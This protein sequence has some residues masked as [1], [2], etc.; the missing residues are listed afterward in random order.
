[1]LSLLR[2]AIQARREHARNEK[3]TRAQLEALQLTKFRKLVRHVNARSPYYT[4]LISELG[5]SVDTC[6]PRDFPVL[7]K[8]ILMQ[9][10]DRIITERSITRQRIAEFLTR[11]KD[12]NELIDGRYHVLHTSGTSGEIGYFVYSEDDWARGLAQGMGRRRGRPRARRKR[13]GR[14]RGAFYG[15]IG[16]HFAGVSMASSASVGLG[17]LFFDL[18]LFE[19]NDPLPVVIHELNEFQPEFISGYTTA[20]KILAAKQREG[21]LKISPIAVGTGGETMTLADKAVLEEA[22]GCE[23]GSGYGCT[24]HLMMGSSTPG[25]RTMILYDDDLIFEFMEDHSLITN[26]Y[27]YTLPL[28]RYRMSDILRPIA[29]SSVSPYIEI[30]CLVGRNER[31]PVFINRDGAED[32]ISPHTINEIFVAGV[33]QFQMQLVDPSRFKFLVCLDP[34]LDPKA[35]SVALEALSQRLRE[36]L[37]QKLMDNVEFEIVVTDQIPL[38]PR[39]RKFQLIVDSAAQN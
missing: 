4:Q 36:I 26:L 23:V 20:L 22:F 12:P 10:F 8:K 30:D 32:F 5:I 27:N 35:R 13:S 24:E 9:N 18:G 7:T 16:G 1:M 29:N 15:A 14:V 3:L 19:V 31:V 17:R 2:I 34:A 6:T 38:N 37:N 39:T 11:S 28:I 21:A 33:A 25:G